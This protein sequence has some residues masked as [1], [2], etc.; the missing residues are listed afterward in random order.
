MCPRSRSSPTPHVRMLAETCPVQTP[1]TARHEPPPTGS[2]PARS[3]GNP[4][5]IGSFIPSKNLENHDELR[6]EPHDERAAPI[7][8]AAAQHDTPARR[9][10]L[11]ARYPR[12]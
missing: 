1:P 2:E 4:W 3:N 8:R 5:T 10:V 12:P 6:Y 11:A 7:C 9:A